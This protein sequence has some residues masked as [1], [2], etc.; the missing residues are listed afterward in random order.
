MT[1]TSNKS[2]SINIVCHFFLKIIHV[3]KDKI[4]NGKNQ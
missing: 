2:I 4:L 1:V 3:C